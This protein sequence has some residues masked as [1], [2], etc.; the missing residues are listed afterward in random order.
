MTSG[1]ANFL[2]RPRVQACGTRSAP[3]GAQTRCQLSGQR[4]TRLDVERLVDAPGRDPHRLVVG[5]VDRQTA[6]DLL[7]APRRGPT[8]VLTAAVAPPDPAHLRSR[9]DGAARGGD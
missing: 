7:R 5:E 2:P 4:P 3:P 8:P 6:G 1:L 9:H